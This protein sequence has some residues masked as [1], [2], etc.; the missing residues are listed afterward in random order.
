MVMVVAAPVVILTVGFIYV[1]HH[2]ISNP[3]YMRRG[4]R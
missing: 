1:D 2:S 4:R 3:R